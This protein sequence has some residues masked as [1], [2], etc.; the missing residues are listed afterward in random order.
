MKCIETSFKFNYQKNQQKGSNAYGQPYD[1][2][3]RIAFVAKQVA[4]SGKKI[5]L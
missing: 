2:N 3:G 1:I 4:I 5:I